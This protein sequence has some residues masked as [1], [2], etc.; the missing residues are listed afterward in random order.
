MMESYKLFRTDRQGRRGREVALHVNKWIGCEKLPLRNRR[1]QIESL[2]V[3]V[4]A[5]Q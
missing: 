5:A 2:W 1:D 3:R 4:Q